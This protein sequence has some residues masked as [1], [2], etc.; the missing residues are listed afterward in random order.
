MDCVAQKAG[1]W[2]ANLARGA[3][4]AFWCLLQMQPW[5]N[6][7]TNHL[8]PHAIR[9]HPLLP[10]SPSHLTWHAAVSPSKVW[11]KKSNSN[12]CD[13]NEA[14]INALTC[15][16]NTHW[17]QLTHLKLRRLHEKMV[18]QN[19]W[20]SACDEVTPP[21]WAPT[22]TGR[23]QYLHN[24]SRNTTALPNFFLKIHMRCWN[25]WHLKGGL[26]DL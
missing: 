19:F 4:I 12:F 18:G 8:N 15:L 16:L 17:T 11:P 13:S 9:F 6:Y 3:V 25:N 1:A 7:S 10:S 24:I 23:T 5:G 22:C 2:L 21:A 14:Q 20:G 26:V